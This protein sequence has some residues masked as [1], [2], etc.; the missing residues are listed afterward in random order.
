[1]ARAIR[2]H[3]DECRDV[4]VAD[5][6]RRRDIDVTTSEQAGLKGADDREQAAYRLGQR[7][8]RF[9]ARAALNPRLPLLHRSWS[10]P[11]VRDR[12]SRAESQ[13]GSH[14]ETGCASA[15]RSER[16]SFWSPWPP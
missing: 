12:E 14:H 7:K 8:P 1:M 15:F 13:G 6:L 9:S 11:R 10:N 5:C 3:L 2:F 4:A 16:W